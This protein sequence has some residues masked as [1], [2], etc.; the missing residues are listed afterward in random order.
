MS[1]KKKQ[2]TNKSFSYIQLPDVELTSIRLNESRWKGTIITFQEVKFEEG[3]NQLH[4]NYDYLIN[5]GNTVLQ[6]NKKFKKYL[7]EIL[8]YILAKEAM[9]PKY[10]SPI[11]EN[12]EH[13]E[14]DTKE[15]L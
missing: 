2:I 13:T 8:I 10:D 11:G 5:H 7:S 6:G 14:I 3:E 9:N 1:R 15:N 4:L 12:D